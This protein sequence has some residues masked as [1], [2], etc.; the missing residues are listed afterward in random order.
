MTRGTRKLRAEDIT[1]IIKDHLVEDRDVWHN[2]EQKVI[3]AIPFIGP[4]FTYLNNGEVIACCGAIK[5]KDTWE[6]WA[7]YSGKASCFQRARA[8]II[9]R[10]RLYQWKKEHPE[11][12][13]IFQIPS[14]L[15]NAKRYGNFIGATFRGTEQDSFYITNNVYEVL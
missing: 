3:D 10:S 11:D 8:A 12:R 6:I 14:D 15:P 7:A 5:T 4:A 2:M 1:A 13:V 9:F